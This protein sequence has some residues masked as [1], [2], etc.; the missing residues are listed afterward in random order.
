MK[1][2]NR[3]VLLLTV[4]LLFGWN[5]SAQGGFR[6]GLNAGAPIGDNGN[7]AAFV[8]NI[9]LEFDIAISEAIYVGVGTGATVYSGKEN[10]NDFKY[11]PI[12][13]SADVQ[14]ID[15]LSLGGDVGYGV[16]LEDNIESGLIYRFLLR[17][18]LTKGIDVTGR[19]SAYSAD[20][21]TLS[22]LSAGIGFR[23]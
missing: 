12:V 15:G 23:F 5:V 4:A 18:Q 20:I 7:F 13:A 1:S 8:A 6:I 21:G 22:D 9:D 10:F 2:L 3:I 11:V 14:V 19:L 17:Y 16:S